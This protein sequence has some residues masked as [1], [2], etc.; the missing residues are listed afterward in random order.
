[1]L[2]A[3]L[4]SVA[5]FSTL[6]PS[7]LAKQCIYNFG[8]ISK[9]IVLW[10]AYIA[11]YNLCN[12]W[13]WHA[14]NYPSVIRYISWVCSKPDYNELGFI[15]RSTLS[16]APDKILMPDGGECAYIPEDVYQF[17]IGSGWTCVIPYQLELTCEA[18]GNPITYVPPNPVPTFVTK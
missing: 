17:V 8:S 2:P 9:N 3:F 12:Y 13:N 18:E 7:T 5:L 6:I 16:D 14:N 10:D 11:D 4:V 15:L 1:M